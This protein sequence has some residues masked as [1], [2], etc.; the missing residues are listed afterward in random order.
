MDY[1]FVRPGIGT[2]AHHIGIQEFV[3]SGLDRLDPQVPEVVRRSPLVGTERRRTVDELFPRSQSAD[4][5]LPHG[6]VRVDDEKLPRRSRSGSGHG[7]RRRRESLSGRRKVDLRCG[8]STRFRVEGMDSVILQQEQRI[9]HS[10][11]RLAPDAPRKF[12]PPGRRSGEPGPARARVARVGACAVEV[13]VPRAVAEVSDDLPTAAAGWRVRDVEAVAAACDDMVR[14]DEAGRTERA[15]GRRERNLN[16]DH[17]EECGSSEP[18][19]G[20]PHPRPEPLCLVAAAVRTF[21]SLLSPSVRQSAS[22]YISEK[23]QKKLLCNYTG[24]MQEGA[25]GRSRFERE[26]GRGKKSL[27]FQI[28]ASIV[29]LPGVPSSRRS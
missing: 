18:S 15:G 6:A 1:R 2:D 4:H 8:R 24:R 20:I 23:N 3:R 10:V 7:F 19:R 5:P 27:A 11:V 16:G 9:V 28:A 22:M 14:T 21:H 17:R 25:S 29:P 13:S 12:L 26:D